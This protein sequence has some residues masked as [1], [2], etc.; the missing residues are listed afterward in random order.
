MST[1]TRSKAPMIL[2]ADD[3]ARTI[4]LPF[5][6]NQND[7]NYDRIMRDLGRIQWLSIGYGGKEEGDNIKLTF[8]Q[9]EYN[10]SLRYLLKFEWKKA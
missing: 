10:C 1:D 3:A 2:T 8:E 9:E 7:T 4:T 5:K 6:V